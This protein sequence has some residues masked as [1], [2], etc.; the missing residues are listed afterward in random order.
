LRRGWWLAACGVAAAG[1][2]LVGCGLLVKTSKPEQVGATTVRATTGPATQPTTRAI[3]WKGGFDPAKALL[4]LESI[5]PSVELA[6][7]KAKPDR[8]I[9]PQAVKHYLAARDLFHQWRNAEA[10]AALEEALRY[11]PG[12]FDCRLLL[13]RAALRAGNAG[14][15]RN[16]LREAAKLRPDDVTCQYL[17]GWL[18]LKSKDVTEALRR[19]RLALL[20]SNAAPRRAET[21]L[22]R[23]RLGEVLLEQGYLSAAI[24]ELE[25]FEEAVAEPR[26][27]FWRNR[28]LITLVRSRRA[29]PSMMIGQAALVLRRYDQAAEAFKRALTFEPGNPR[30]KG[31]YAQAL[32]RGGHREE[33][34]RLAREMALAK[35]TTAA[36]VELLGWI[37]KDAG[38]PKALI[39]ELRKL[40]AEH[41]DRGDLWVMLADTLI[42][43]GRKDQAEQVLRESMK[44][45]P[46]RVSAY[47]RLAKML[48]DQGRAPEAVRVLADAVAAGPVTHVGVLRAVAR[49]GSKTQTIRGLVDQA[50]RILASDEK[51]HALCYVMGM[52]AFHGD[53]QELA[54]RCFNRTAGLKKDFL[55]AYLSLG[56]LYLQRFEW[57]QAVEVAGRAKQAGL[58]DPS[59]GYL[60]ARAYDGLDEIDKAVAVYLGVIKAQP[61]SVPAMVALGKLYERMGER[62]KAQREYQR[63]LK[64]APAN[65]E[66]GERLIR[67]LLTRGEVG[68]AKKAFHQ[69]RRARGSRHVLGRCLA[70][71]ESRGDMARY[72]RLI[73]KLLEQSG[74]DVKTRYDLA[75][76]YYS[77]REYEE[78]RQEVDRILALAPGHQK[79]RFLMAELCRKQLD[80]ESAAKVMAGLL[81][82]HPNRRA[83]LLAQ[84]EVYLDMQAFDRAAAVFERLVALARNEPRRRAYRMR[85]VG[86]HAA[87]RQYDKA[88]AVAEK[89]VDQDADSVTARR[90]LLEALHEAGQDDRAI[91]L[92]KQWMGAGLDKVK[93]DGKPAG[94]GK[95]AEHVKEKVERTIKN[96]ERFIKDA[97][98]GKK[99]SDDA[100]RQ[101]GDM[102]ISAY[103]S[104]KRHD[105]G[106]ETLLGWMEDDP[107]NRSLLRQVWLVL[108]DARRYD[109]AV[110]LCKSAIATIQQPRAY[111]LMLA[112][113]YME[114][115]QYDEVLAVLKDIPKSDRDGLVM[116]LEI[117]G[118]LGAKR[119][120]EA[121]RIAEKAVAGAR[122]EETRLVNSRLLVLIHQRQG[123]MD[124]AE[125]ELAKIY[126]AQPKDPGVNNDLGYTWADAGRN[127]D[128]AERMVRYALGQE[129]RNPAYM[130]SLG[131]VLYKKGDFAGAVRYLR[132]STR[133][134]GGDDPIIYDHLGDA[135]WRLGKRDEA[136]TCWEQSVALLLKDQAENKEPAEPDTLP[137]VRKKL[138]ELKRGSEPSVAGVVGRATSTSR[139]GQAEVKP[140]SAPTSR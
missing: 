2:S 127:V 82:E 108:F 34:L 33:G 84:G 23:F 41:P 22:A 16:H 109:D 46:K 53:R 74:K 13:G 55:P 118:L 37:Y 86:V 8:A 69:F 65:P 20:C 45:A 43:F 40:L 87:A 9:P 92:A 123:R 120:D 70:V 112:Q 5:P 106:L 57:P 133:A 48:T 75:T 134:Q 73:N 18:A 67:I 19:L 35:G 36:G 77:T 97:R 32:A 68:E 17:L 137:R 93:K 26:G 95:D 91:R 96:A 139:P 132:K 131:W 66:A 59:V 104:A 117:M 44:N 78:A 99:T 58:K 50:D 79:A 7:P 85:L 114:A 39:D 107:S 102:L 76:S 90:L 42:A 140:T 110:E 30:T 11:D 63:A 98:R 125:K 113:T 31:R 81:R 105:Q 27:A 80:Y 3:G 88:V 51:N 72:R 100:R 124:L 60:L 10:I 89:W 38:R 56:Q 135:C 122:K 103:V 21:L 121:L 119:F 62:N 1:M 12:S 14:Q 126:A 129:S 128:R 52:V 6:A 71:M 15:A 54:I 4:P 94:R 83:W 64:I 116:R 49:L 28:E 25:A 115:R 136:K 61:K 24:K 138:A 101:A 47:V 111:R 130:D 29:L